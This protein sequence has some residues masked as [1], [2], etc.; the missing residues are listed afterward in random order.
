M[1]QERDKKT[2]QQKTGRDRQKNKEKRSILSSTRVLSLALCICCMLSLS[3]CGKVIFVTGMGWN[4]LFT[5]GDQ[6]GSQKE[7]NVY[8][9][10]LQN[11]YK[12]TY[13]EDVFT[14]EGNDTVAESLK[15]YALELLVKVK[16]L[17]GM[18]EGNGISLDE[19]ELALAEQASSLYW[20]ELTK[21]D[22]EYLDVEKTLI[23]QMYDEYALAVKTAE[24][25]IEDVDM[26][27]SDDDART[28]TVQS[29]L[30]RTYD[31]DEEGNRVE[32]SEEEKQEAKEYAQE[33]RDEIQYGMDNY[34]GITFAEYIAEYNEDSVSTYT[35][36][37]G[38][39]DSAFEEAAFNQQIGT[40]SDVIETEDGYRIIKT[41]AL[42]DDEEIEANKEILVQEKIETAYESIYNAYVQELDYNLNKNRWAQIELCSEEEVT[43]SNF[44]AVYE[45]EFGES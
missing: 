25:L 9:V 41:I 13:G 19:S 32:F 12:Q 43:T 26:E 23:Q 45:Q 24:S 28:V 15:E 27:I 37:K 40:I 14:R 11:L 6:S 30:I 39:V 36:G 35:F 34:L 8:F 16:V 42:S 29:I 38:E 44:F 1:K 31:I 10:T 18:A 2:N 33:I 5:V 22:I 3:G 17:N 21:E 4:Q 20:D 7:F